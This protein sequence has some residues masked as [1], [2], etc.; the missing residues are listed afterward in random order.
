MIWPARP[1]TAG[2][3][4]LVIDATSS[5]RFSDIAGETVALGTPDER[6]QAVISTFEVEVNP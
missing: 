6:G 3:Y 2:R 5:S 1:L 4:R